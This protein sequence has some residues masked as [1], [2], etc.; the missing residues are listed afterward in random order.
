[1]PTMN[2]ETLHERYQRET[3][4]DFARLEADLAAKDAEMARLSKCLFVVNE[5]NA[6]LRAELAQAREALT[7]A[8]AGL[9]ARANHDDMCSITTLDDE[10]R[11]CAC[12]CGFDELIGTLRAA[13]KGE[14]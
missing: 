13:I 2:D 5:D 4:G 12:D 7:L 9:R 3:A 1:M 8:G 11:H 6:R 10:G 14:S